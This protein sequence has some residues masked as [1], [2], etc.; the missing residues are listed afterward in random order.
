MTTR[1]PSALCALALALGLA[2]SGSGCM[3][4]V[5]HDK[6]YLEPAGAFSWLVIEQDI[7]S[8]HA[9]PVERDKEENA[10]LEPF[11]RGEHNV[12]RAFQVAGG[13][14]LRSEMIRSRRP[15]AILT[16]ARFEG[17][18]SLGREILR[19]TRWVGTSDRWMESDEW[20]F[21]LTMYPTDEPEIPEADQGD[22]L[23]LIGG[24]GDLQVILTE[25][26]FTGATGFTF[27]EGKDT[28][29]IDK[30]HFE[31]YDK[32]AGV[33]FVLELRWTENR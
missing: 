12:A 17:L 13:R 23:A 1:I 22:L 24:L 10:F 33:P 8:D 7:R 19:L 16:E 14:E 29:T 21:R 9:D 20:V 25:G 5:R 32:D 28:A 18:E 31:A 3:H 30:A 11:R 27:E 26:S 4:V 15:Y 6:I 2:L